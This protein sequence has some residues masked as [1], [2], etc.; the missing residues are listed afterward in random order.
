MEI[1]AKN[2]IRR[3]AE[4]AEQQVF[5]KVEG[6]DLQTNDFTDS[7]I[8]ALLTM[9]EAGALAL[10]ASGSGLPLMLLCA[11]LPIPLNLGA[12]R[13][14][15]HLFAEP[16]DALDRI[17]HYKDYLLP[18]RFTEAEVHDFESLDQVLQ[19]GAQGDLGASKNFGMLWARGEIAYC[20]GMIHRLVLEHQTRQDTWAAEQTLDDLRVREARRLKQE[21]RLKLSHW[22]QRR[23]LA[24]QADQ[25]AYRRW[26]EQNGDGE[27]V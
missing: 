12:A 9:V 23:E 1:D 10:L 26:L 27:V 14:Q 22:Q 5:L 25:D 15:D 20:E 4:A 18:E 16:E 21:Y 3:K 19:A 6:Q 24:Q 11:F 17:E 8:F 7:I 13:F 2:W